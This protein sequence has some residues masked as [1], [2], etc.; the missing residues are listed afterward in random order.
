M[1]R[2]FVMIAALAVLAAVLAIGVASA[3]GQV[4]TGGG[5][6]TVPG[7]G[8]VSPPSVPQCSDLSDHDGVGLVDMNDPDR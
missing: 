8:T 7:V 2:N 3:A 5:S 4:G 6:V 1:R